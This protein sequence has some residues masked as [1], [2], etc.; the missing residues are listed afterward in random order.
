MSVGG[1]L[2][3]R[4]GGAWL[5]SPTLG[6]GCSRSLT[7]S[8]SQSILE[9]ELQLELNLGSSVKLAALLRWTLNNNNNKQ[10]PGER[11]RWAGG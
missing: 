10:K 9:L 7:Q 6:S 11:E 5:W 1:F 8:L 3:A 2:S 4:S